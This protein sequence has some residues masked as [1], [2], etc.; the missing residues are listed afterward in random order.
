MFEAR[1]PFLCGLLL[2]CVFTT[3]TLERKSRFLFS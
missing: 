1:C 3:H 2:L